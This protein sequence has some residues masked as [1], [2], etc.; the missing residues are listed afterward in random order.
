MAAGKDKDAEGLAPHIIRNVRILPK[1]KELSQRGRSRKSKRTLDDMIRPANE[2]QP[3]RLERTMIT[4]SPAKPSRLIAS[5]LLLLC[6][7]APARGEPASAA[8]APVVHIDNFVFQP[9]EIT[10]A[11]GTTLNWINRDDIPH[12]VAGANG[13]FR[14]KALD[15][16]QSFSFTFTKPGSYDY[17]C[18]LHP[19][20]K[21]KVVVK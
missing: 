16:D 18:A 1:P 4:C 19:H 13:E 8:A 5:A 20:M 15:T 11:P 10:I 14:S 9:A 12:L 2:D 17:F 6:I 7:A 3:I 21:G